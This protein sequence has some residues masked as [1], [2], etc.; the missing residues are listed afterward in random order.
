MYYMF[1]AKYGIGPSVDFVAQSLDFSF[2]QISK[3]ST[4]ETR[5]VL[6]LSATFG[7]LT[8][9][10]DRSHVHRLEAKHKPI[11]VNRGGGSAAMLFPLAVMAA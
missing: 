7:T 3:D 6:V 10:L 9:M 11:H 2:I 1:G 4:V 5:I 8:W